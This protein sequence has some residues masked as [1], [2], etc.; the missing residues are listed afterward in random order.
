MMMMMTDGDGYYYLFTLG[1][2]MFPIKF[3]IEDS[4]KFG[5]DHQSVQS[6]A[7]KVPCN[8]TAL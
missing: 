3:K 6:G 4:T 1:R 5:T 7:G 8:K 2:Y